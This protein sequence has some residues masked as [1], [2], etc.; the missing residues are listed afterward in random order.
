M[1]VVSAGVLSMDELVIAVVL[2]YPFLFLRLL[3][4]FSSFFFFCTACRALVW[5]GSK[6]VI[7]F[8]WM[9]RQCGVQ[10]LEETSG[11]H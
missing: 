1:E 3:L 11:V 2:S 7:N 4:L 6:G 10:S 9:F 5:V 8:P